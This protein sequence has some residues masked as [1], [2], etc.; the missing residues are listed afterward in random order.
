MPDHVDGEMCDSSEDDSAAWPDSWQPLEYELLE[1]ANSLPPAVAQHLSREL[2]EQSRSAAQLRC[3]NRRLRHRLQRIEAAELAATEG[4]IRDLQQRTREV[5]EAMHQELESL[6]ERSRAVEAQ[7]RQLSREREDDERESTELREATAHLVRRRGH[8]Q[9]LR[10]VQAGAERRGQE[11][12]EEE[13]QLAAEIE[14]L[15][16]ELRALKARCNNPEKYDAFEQ[17]LRA[18]L[19]STRGALDAAKAAAAV[20]SSR[21]S[22]A[23][24]AP[25]AASMVGAAA[26]RR[27]GSGYDPIAMPR[28]ASTFRPPL[29][30]AGVAGGA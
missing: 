7:E 6:A 5:D 3:A 22:C 18:E 29:R 10:R 27:L 19:R 26:R 12:G 14:H 11:S 2:E 8:V 23:P 1:Y 21:T 15:K 28:K 13:Y 25:S 9:Q 17:Q 4:R 24:R 16:A 20:V 30:I